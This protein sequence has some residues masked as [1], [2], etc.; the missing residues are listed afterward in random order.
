M[1]AAVQKSKPFGEDATNNQ[2]EKEGYVALNC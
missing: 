2:Q 1:N